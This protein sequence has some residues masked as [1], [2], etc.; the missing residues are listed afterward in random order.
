MS[1]AAADVATATS[2]GTRLGRAISRVVLNRR[3]VTFAVVVAGWHLLALAVDIDLFPTPARVFDKILE[4][5]AGGLFFDQLADSMLRI[6]IGFG[7][8]LVGGTV[9]GLLMGSRRFWNDFFQDLI[10]L[11]LSLPG[12]IYALLTV[13][14]FGIGL[15]APVVAIALASLPFVAVNIKEGVLAL[16]KPMLEMCRV[17]RVGRGRLIRKV[18][19]PSLL[20][21]MMAAIRIGFTVAWKVAVLTEVFGAT[22]GIGYQMR[23]E[24]QL[25]SVR[26]IMAW[27]LLFG[28]VMLLIEYGL[29][30]PLERH[31]GRW[32]PKLERVI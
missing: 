27:A 2:A 32:R 21:F 13:M 26:G 4:A 29:L 18:V 16:D 14:I 3:W 23:Y 15:T 22:S 31:F 19:A 12:L 24:F 25:F 6:V 10:V 28:V 30:I 5:L 11:G 8:G 20:P 9:V 17:Y 7:A 1:S